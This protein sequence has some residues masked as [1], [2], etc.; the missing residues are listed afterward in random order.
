LSLG[1][2]NSWNAGDA[3][4]ASIVLDMAMIVFM[5]FGALYAIREG[6]KKAIIYLGIVVGIFMLE[7]I[8]TNFA[9]T[10]GENDVGVFVFAGIFFLAPLL[11]IG[12][13][14]HEVKDHPAKGPAV[15]RFNRKIVV[16]LLNTVMLAV[17]AIF[18]AAG[19]AGTFYTSWLEALIHISFGGTTGTMTV[20]IIFM[21]LTSIG[22]VACIGVYF[23]NDRCRSIVVVMST[24]TWY[25]VFPFGLALVLSEND[26]KSWFRTSSTR[27]DAITPPSE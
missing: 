10:G 25:F 6:Y 4:T 11:L 14:D 20:G 16:P 12:H 5:I 15:A 22:I 26:V 1:D 23:K 13:A 9:V 2:L 3:M 24:L 19:I 7:V 8:A 21:G 27:S 18:F 17:L